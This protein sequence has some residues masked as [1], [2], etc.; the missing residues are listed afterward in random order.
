MTTRSLSYTIALNGNPVTDLDACTVDEGFN[1]SSTRFEMTMHT[2]PACSVND[3]VSITLGY[4]A[5]AALIFTGYIDNIQ[6]TNPDGL[7]TVTGRDALKRAA[8]HLL[9]PVNSEDP[10]FKRVN[11][12]AETLVQ[13]LLAE[14]GLVNYGS[15]VSGFTFLEPEF[16]LE[17]VYG[18]IERICGILQWHC[19]ADTA[20]KVWFQ[21]IKPV[22]AGAAVANFTVGVGGNLVTINYR[23]SDEDLRNKVVVFGKEDIYAEASAASPYVPAGYY[24]TAV[25]ASPLID[26]QQMADGA[27]NFNLTAWNKLTEI[28]EAEA[29]G[30]PNVHVR[31]TVFVQ[32]AFTGRNENWFVYTC[33]HRFASDKTY[34]L[35]LTLIK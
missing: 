20:G 28:V 5:G 26:T 30:N 23:Q 33:S 12:S 2:L 10:A 7:T 4:V 3:S 29:E 35:G 6:P 24:K 1:Q 32:D 21:D 13:D 25:V 9:V 18:A 16:S 8:E 27:A 17:F 11:I 14:C 22:P 15:D 19:Y 34:K 31:D